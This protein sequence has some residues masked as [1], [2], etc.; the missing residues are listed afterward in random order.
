MAPANPFA[1]MKIAFIIVPSMMPRPV[2][3]DNFGLVSDSSH[4]HMSQ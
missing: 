4:S 1:N 2:L 3:K